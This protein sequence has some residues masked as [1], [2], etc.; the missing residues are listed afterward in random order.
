MRHVRCWGFIILISVE[1]IVKKNKIKKNVAGP[2]NH[3]LRTT[4]LLRTTTDSLLTLVSCAG[5]YL[6]FVFQ[7]MS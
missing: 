7:K 1:Y 6:V 2:E 4:G 5:I 3:R